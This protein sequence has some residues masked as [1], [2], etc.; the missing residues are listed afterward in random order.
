VKFHPESPALIPDDVSR[1]KFIADL[2]RHLYFELGPRNRDDYQR[3]AA[4]AAGPQPPAAAAATREEIRRVMEGRPF[5]QLWSSLVRAAP[6]LPLPRA[7][8][9]CAR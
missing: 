2:K 7:A 3:H 4:E 6:E 8:A 9:G 5:F 1:L